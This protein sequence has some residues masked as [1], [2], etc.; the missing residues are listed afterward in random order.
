MTTHDYVMYTAIFSDLHMLSQLN[1]HNY[2]HKH[3]VVTI[4]MQDEEAC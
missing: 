4:Y 2:Y 3:E 1:K